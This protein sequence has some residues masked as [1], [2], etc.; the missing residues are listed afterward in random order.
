MTEKEINE[1]IRVI[2]TNALRNNIL[3]VRNI[4]LL[5]GSIIIDLHRCADALEKIAS[6]Y[7]VKS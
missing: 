6:N 3:P 2:V 5:V 4:G 1:V 7:V